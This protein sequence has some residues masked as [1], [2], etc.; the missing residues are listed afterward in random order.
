VS[1]QEN[2]ELGDDDR[3]RE[4]RRPCFS[5]DCA[6]SSL[7]EFGSDR[8]VADGKVRRGMFAGRRGGFRGGIVTVV[9]CWAAVLCAGESW[10]DLENGW[11]LTLFRVHHDY[12]LL[13]YRQ[14]FSE[15]V[16][17]QPWKTLKEKWIQPC[18]EGC[19]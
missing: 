14:L 15:L 6:P 5:S 17:L 16:D 19:A 9:D 2:S 3:E 10:R 8:C 12:E 18:I 1:L 4:D 11:D 13:S 7:S